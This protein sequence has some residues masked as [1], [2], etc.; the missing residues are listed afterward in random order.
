MNNNYYNAFSDN[1]DVET[2]ELTREEYYSTP[3]L[4]P[5]VVETNQ[6]LQRISDESISPVVYKQAKNP[7][8]DILGSEIAK[9]YRG[10]WIFNDE[11]NCWMVYELKQSGIWCKVNDNHIEGLINTELNNANIVGYGHSGYR[12]NVISK[13]KVEL[14]ETGWEEKSPTELLPFQNCVLEVAT[15]NILNHSPEYRFTWC[16]PREF[17]NSSDKFPLISNWL[18]EVT[19]NNDLI[20]EILLFYLAAIL[21]GRADSQQFLHLIGSGGTGKS[22][23]VKLA[24]SL[25]GDNNVCTMTLTDLCRQRFAAAN[26]FK[27]RLV[28]FPDQDTYKGDLQKFKSLTGQDYIFAEEKGKQGFQFLFDGMVIMAS[29]DPVFDTRNSSWLTRRQIL[30][31]FTRTVDK[32]KRR[33]L[34]KEFQPE[35]NALTQYL[36]SIPYDKVTQ[37][38]RSASDNPELAQHNLEQQIS[39]NPMAGWIDECVIRD[40]SSKC[41]IGS[42]KSN[43]STLFGNYTEW[44]RKSGYYAPSLRS[45]SPELLDFCKST[46]G[47]NE[48]KKTRNNSG[49]VMHGLRLR[50]A[51]EDDRL[52]S[53]LVGS[54]ESNLH[55]AE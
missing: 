35:L 18:D 26:A 34:E 4:L 36:L 38:L 5:P 25:I 27:K 48:V 31:P 30:V 16:L 22:T 47:W 6:H 51:V 2:I 14:I 11:A 45:F 17:D 23:F 1:E 55:S 8:E 50:Q 42:D 20:K 33:D 19:N 52:P 44:C 3:L 49:F 54:V 7:P 15:G 41:P 13:V 21:K 53:P 43:I 29:N 40:A 12:S 9:K 46:M 39:S 37:V 24:Q 32:S 10:K 28:V